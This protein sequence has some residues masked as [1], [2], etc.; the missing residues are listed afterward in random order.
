LV[1]IISKYGNLLQ[2]TGEF[3]APLKVD[4]TNID[5]A[6]TRLLEIWD[7][8]E[9]ETLGMCEIKRVSWNPLSC[10]Q[11]ANL[12]KSYLEL[13]GEVTA[14]IRQVEKDIDHANFCFRLCLGV[15]IAAVAVTLAA[16]VTGGLALAGVGI[17]AATATVTAV[18]AT[19][20]SAE[21]IAAIALVGAGVF[22]V[23]AAATG[24]AAK[25]YAEI[26]SDLT[27]LHKHY[28]KVKAG[29]AQADSRLGEIKEFLIQINGH[30]GYV[31]KDQDSWKSFKSKAMRK[32]IELATTDNKNL[33]T[34]IE[35][36]FNVLRKQRQKYQTKLIGLQQVL[37]T[38][39]DSCILL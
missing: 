14:E 12:Q 19:A 13:I 2:K 23:T 35:K 37:T 7:E 25:L 36:L 39:S 29:S 15:A 33:L 24:V 10:D 31:S 22:G 30:Q 4:A 34:A 21:V 20:I 8:E 9:N 32:C 38:S 17:F 11:I 28:A 6:L 18:G 5:L 3:I 16:V 26:E 1:S 27:K